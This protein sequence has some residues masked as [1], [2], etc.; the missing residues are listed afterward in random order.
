MGT[1]FCLEYLAEK[2]PL[3]RPRSRW[4]DNIRMHLREIWWESVDWIYLAQDRASGGF[5]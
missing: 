4:D 1:M 2:R 3:G 5:L